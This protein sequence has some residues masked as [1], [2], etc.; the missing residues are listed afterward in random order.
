MRRVTDQSAS[1][2]KRFFMRMSRIITNGDNE[3]RCRKEISRSRKERVSLG[4]LSVSNNY[5]N[6]NNNRRQ[7]QTR[8]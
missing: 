1:F 5:E 3:W 8:K 6:D 7:T 2:A 4:A